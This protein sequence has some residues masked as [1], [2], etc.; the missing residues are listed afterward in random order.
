MELPEA[1]FLSK[2]KRAKKKRLEGKAVTIEKEQF[3]IVNTED[4]SLYGD[5]DFSGG[6][7]AQADSELNRFLSTSPELKDKLQVVSDYEVVGG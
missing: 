2:E 4:L 5:I 1:R 3:K 6:T 7:K